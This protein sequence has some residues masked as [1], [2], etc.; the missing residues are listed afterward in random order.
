MHNLCLWWRSQFLDSVIA[1]TGQLSIS[2][3]KFAQKK[4]LHKNRALFSI[5]STSGL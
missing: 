3:V 4:A 2:W 5:R 1:V